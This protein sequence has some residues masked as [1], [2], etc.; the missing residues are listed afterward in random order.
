MITICFLGNFVIF[1]SPNAAVYIALSFVVHIFKPSTNIA[2]IT[3]PCEN[4]TSAISEFPVTIAPTAPNK[5]I[6]K[7]PIK[8]AITVVE[9][10]TFLFFE[11]L[12]KSGVAVP[13][14]IKDPTHNVTAVTNAILVVGSIF[15]NPWTPPTEFVAI[16]ADVLPNIAMAGTAIALN[17]VSDFIP[18]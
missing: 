12:A 7:L 1:E 4:I 13:P 17:I 16:I 11:N 14:L 10:A 3:N 9:T 18:K 15:I 6:N 5:N 8:N 2:G